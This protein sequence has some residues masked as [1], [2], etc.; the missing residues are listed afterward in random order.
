MRDLCSQKKSI[1]KRSVSLAPAVKIFSRAEVDFSVPLAFMQ[2]TWD[3]EGKSGTIW[4]PPQPGFSV[5]TSRALPGLCSS[6]WPRHPMCGPV[7]GPCT[8]CTE[9][10]GSHQKLKS[11]SAPTLCHRTSSS[12]LQLHSPDGSHPTLP[13]RQ[14]PRRHRGAG[15]RRENED[16]L[17]QAVTEAEGAAL[18]LRAGLFPLGGSMSLQ[19]PAAPRPAG[20]HPLPARNYRRVNFP[21]NPAQAIKM[22]M[23]WGKCLRWSKLIRESVAL[24][25]R[26]TVY[27]FWTRSYLI[28]LA[29]WI[30][31]VCVDQRPSPWFHSE[32]EITLMKQKFEGGAVFLPTLSFITEMCSLTCLSLTTCSL[33]AC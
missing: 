29:T 31:F 10:L 7:A 25:G 15:M 16:S 21:E 12:A 5:L 8:P 26:G 22:L 13:V 11:I 1:Q 24:G 3:N 2:S 32:F 4:R 9:K 23:L 6:S 19:L 17:L 20:E 30:I 27:W 18:R 14:P 28:R 33:R